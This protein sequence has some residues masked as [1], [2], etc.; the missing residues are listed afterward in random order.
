MVLF[1]FFKMKIVKCQVFYFNVTDTYFSC[2]VCSVFDIKLFYYPF[3]R[4]I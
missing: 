4:A 2:V 1:I 3:K